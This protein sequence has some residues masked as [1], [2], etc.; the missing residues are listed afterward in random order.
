MM[1]IPVEGFTYIFGDNQSVLANSSKPHSMLK[2]M[3]CSIAYLFVREGTAQDKW[4]TTYLNTN[5]N[6]S[7]MLTKSILG[8]RNVVGLRLCIALSRM[9]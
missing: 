8:E 1:G 2:K 9:R 5:L 3:S 6:P 4:R 7:D